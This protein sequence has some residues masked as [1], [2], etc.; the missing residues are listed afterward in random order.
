MLTRH[1]L[2][3]KESVVGAIRTLYLYRTSVR[4]T[5]P[6]V[7]VYDRA[8]YPKRARLNLIVDYLVAT[9]RIPPCAMPLAQN[10]LTLIPPGDEPYGILGS[11]LGGLMALYT[12]MRLSKVFGR[13]LCQS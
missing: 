12:G 9:K 11:S 2:S 5:V 7:V 10:H 1:T 4:T 6:L 3:T 13:V 8:D